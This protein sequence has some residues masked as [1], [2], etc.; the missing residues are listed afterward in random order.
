MILKNCECDE[1]FN[2]K[3]DRIM[4]WGKG[5][6]LKN[7]YNEIVKNEFYKQ[8][9]YIIDRDTTENVK[10][11]DHLIPVYPKEKL[12]EEKRCTILITSTKYFIEIYEELQDLEL[13]DSV[14]CYILSFARMIQN[15]D[16]LEFGK[17]LLQNNKKQFLPHVLHTFWFSGDP[18]PEDYKKCLDSWK[19]Y[20]PNYEIKIWNQKT[21]DCN[22][23]T[24]VKKAIETKKW[25][26]ATDVARLDVLYEYGGI[27]MDL[28]VEIYQALDDLL[29]HKGVFFHSGEYIDMPVFSSVKGNPLLKK[30]LS[31]YDGLEFTDDEYYQKNMLIQPR[32][33][34]PIFE[35]EGV[36]MEEG[37]H[38]V[39]GNL[40]LPRN[41]FLPYY[42]FDWS[43]KSK[44]GD[45]G[46]GIHHC[47]AGWYSDSSREERNIKIS[48]VAALWD[49]IYS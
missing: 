36:P 20:C 22:K 3:S 18:L 35:A 4:L 21:Y 13:P 25:A 34:K 17:R 9:A 39:N 28:D 38:E 11:E 33:V 46:Y 24:F 47:N 12:K 37:V 19:K 27:Y 43:G 2:L 41:M 10:I 5:L 48:K 1:F 45:A 49:K 26:F 8:I 30:L 23:S 44:C 31:F 42:W 29:K 40:Y 6:A 32:F 7:C 14:E 15:K 16:I